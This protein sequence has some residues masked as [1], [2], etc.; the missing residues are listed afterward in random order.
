MAESNVSISPDNTQSGAHNIRTITVNVDNSSVVAG[1][2]PEQQEVT[3]LADSTGNLL[4]FKDGALPIRSEELA[5]LVKAI[6][7]R[8]DYLCALM[9]KHYQAPDDLGLGG[10]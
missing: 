6:L 2:Q 7:W 9:D 5:L 3:A 10:S 4:A 8:L 1:G